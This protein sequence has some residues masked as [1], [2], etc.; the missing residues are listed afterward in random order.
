MSG[1]FILVHEY[2]TGGG[3]APLPDLPSLGAEGDAMLRAVVEDFKAWGG[4]RIVATRDRRFTGPPLSADET[5]RLAPEEYED[6]FF[7]LAARARAVLVIAPEEGGLLADMSERILASGGRLLGSL[8]QGVRLAGDKWASHEIWRR[9]GLPQP[10][11]ILAPWD[12]ARS[13]ALD[14]GFPL[15]AKTPDGQG[16]LGV[17]LARDEP[18]LDAALAHLPETENL[19]IQRYREGTHASVSFLVSASGVLP[20]C[21]NRQRIAPGVPFAYHGGETPFREH[22]DIGRA[23]DAAE[24]AVSSIPG[25][26]GFVG[27]D[28]VLCGGQCLLIEINPRITVAY[29]GVRQIVNCNLA[30]AVMRACLEDALP[31]GLALTGRAVFNP[32]KNGHDATP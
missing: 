26:R 21:A 25:L 28:M 12:K 24:K 17:C 6:R 29:T 16:S 3:F 22:P 9:E 11:T 7:D 10:E 27:V 20:L 5:V 13:A 1:D 14:F 18:S 31:E 8:P 23:M 2:V 19:L 30:Q 15:V 4:S 32:R